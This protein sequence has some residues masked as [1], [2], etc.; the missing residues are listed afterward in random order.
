MSVRGSF[1]QRGVT[2]V[3]LIVTISV[4]SL[5]GVSLVSTLS[6]ITGAGGDHVLQAQA[7]SIA[8]A[9]LHEI[10]GKCF[11]DCQPGPENSRM[12]FDDVTDYNGLNT[13]VATDQMNNA[14]GNFNVSVA[15]T[16]GTLGVL[17]AADVWRIDVTV[18]YGEGNRAI[19]TGYKTNHP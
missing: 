3:E 11:A 18:Q 2:L 16:A 13:V 17:P 8:D 10:T 5:A 12:E 9:Y 4:I 6:Y 7:Q 15:L 19:A 1:R 14:G